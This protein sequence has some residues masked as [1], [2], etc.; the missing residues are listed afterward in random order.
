[1]R[2]EFMKE[3]QQDNNQNDQDIEIVDID[4]GPVSNK[5]IPSLPQP[6]LSLVPRQRRRQVIVTVSLVVLVLIVL[7]SSNVS[8]RNKLVQAV[9]PPTPTPIAPITLGTDNFYASGDVGWGHLF[10]DGKL[11]PHLPIA[12]SN[13]SIPDAPIH[14][15][16]GTH[17]LL[18]RDDPFPPK[19]CTVS[20]PNNYRTDTC[21]YDNFVSGTG[22]NFNFPADITTLPAVS[23]NALLAATQAALQSYASNDVIQTGEI[24]TTDPVSKQ[25]SI[26][27]ESLK[28]T[29]HYELDTDISASF[30]DCSP[31]NFA[32]GQ[33]GCIVGTQDCRTFCVA[34]TYF[35]TASTTTHAWNVFAAAR[36]VWDYTTLA[37]KP[38][39]QHQ[40][41]QINATSIVDHLIPLQ[42][43]WDGT[44]WYVKSSF[45]LISNNAVQS[46]TSPVC[47]L[48]TFSIPIPVDEAQATAS[49][50]LVAASKAATGCLGIVTLDSRQVIHTSQT[51]ALC[52]YRFGLFLAAND[53]AH[54][55]WPT[56]PLADAHEK[57][58]AQELAKIYKKTT[59]S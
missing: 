13:S 18:W 25:Q 3:E 52:L 49:W 42:I 6:L 38:V 37:D 46:F 34:S 30:V 4:D 17:T 32:G 39:V 19:M 58:L 21:K 16:R 24:Y 27:H 41:D 26:A 57:Q 2:E 12:Y 50:N 59:G 1:M 28:V 8:I 20:V 54:K 22:W 56:M 55:Y 44:Q 10:L 48:A 9:V 11:I 35:N 43:S 5:K 36:S 23:R 33:L 14:L 53:V 51:P 40:V 47:D 7:I 31:F 45:S 15:T 29:L